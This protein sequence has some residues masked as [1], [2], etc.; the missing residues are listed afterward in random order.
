MAA[1]IESLQSKSSVLN[2]KLENRKIVER[3]LRP[4]VEEL[5]ISPAT[6]RKI[7]E[8]AVD[9]AWIRA[10]DE[11]SRK[12]R[13][14]ETK[15]RAGH[16]VK[17]IEDLKPLLENLTI[18]AVERIRDFLV[19]QIKA[20]RSPGINAQIIQQQGFL[21]NKDLYVF[22]AKHQRV[23]ADDIAQAY[24]NT[25][26]WYYLH[27][28]GRYRDA[29]SALKLFA[30]DQNHVLG[31][32]PSTHTRGVFGP[33]R[34]SPAA[35]A[36]VFS[37]GRRLEVLKHSPSTALPS[38][39]ATEDKNTHHLETPFHA[40]N[41]ALIDNAAAEYSF[42]TTFFSPTQSYHTISSTF[43][44]IFSPTLTLGSEL[45]KSL[46]E[47]TYDAVGVLIAVRLVQHFAF[48]LQ[49]R[50]VPTLDGYING[51]NMLLW[52]RFQQIIDAHCESIRRLAPGS[53]NAASTAI[54]SL[55]S[56]ST[57]SPPGES[58]TAPHPLTHRFAAFLSSLLSL[59]T[60]ATEDAEPVSTSL[61][62]LRD[63]Y[64]GF[65]NRA[66][67]VMGARKDVWLR[68]QY[69]FVGRLIEGVKGR[70][71]EDMREHFIELRG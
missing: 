16:K 15:G 64:E 39:L 13:V 14:V 45:T 35:H 40:F 66:A 23:L 71:A 17:A 37:V 27:N 56:S 60:S 54:S 9:D 33:S 55:R 65:L 2:R 8:G 69:E 52:P 1:E 18:K 19:A 3:L 61:S 47:N 20:L 38:H 59:A 30:I 7:C 4:A 50:K 31:V 41:L 53:R 32:D 26:R 6:V 67:R 44:Q 12:S 70:L 46:I 48:V 57:V 42:L 11:I 51:T 34:A 21:R 28:F 29:L 62:R 36:D 25:M 10:L 22:L 43:T 68:N 63:E 5:S 49:R 58:S 24:I